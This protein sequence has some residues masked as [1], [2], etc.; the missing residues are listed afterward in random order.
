M[1]IVNLKF[2]EI[3]KTLGVTKSTF[4]RFGTFLK[5]NDELVSSG[6]SEGPENHGRQLWWIMM[7]NPR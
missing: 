3:A 2:R 4:G 7:M 5:T 1:V 6:T